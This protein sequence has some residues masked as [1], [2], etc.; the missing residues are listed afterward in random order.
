MLESVI[1]GYLNHFQILIF[2]T[3]FYL[4]RKFAHDLLRVDFNKK[5]VA[6]SSKLALC[7]ITDWE[8]D[9]E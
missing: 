1:F 6:K 4:N 2:L 9:E 7:G 8:K 5:I 3:Q